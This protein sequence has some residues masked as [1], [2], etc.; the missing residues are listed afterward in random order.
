VVLSVFASPSY[1]PAG[2]GD[3]E[4]LGSASHGTSC[5]LRLLSSQPVT[6]V[7]SHSPNGHCR[8]G[9]YSANV[10]I[11]PN[12]GALQRTVT[13]ALLARNATSVSSDRF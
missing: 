11:G 9:S 2:G 8:S 7:Y 10:V 12:T 5:Q 4:I 13:F 1:L 3:L 6:V